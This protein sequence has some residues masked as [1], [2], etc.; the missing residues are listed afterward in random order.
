MPQETDPGSSEPL[1]TLGEIA[2]FI[3]ET[4][5]IPI[6]VSTVEKLA[7]PAIND[8]PKPA[9]YIG[10]RP[11]F[12]RDE[13]A[14]WAKARL[15]ASPKRSAHNWPDRPPKAKRTKSPDKTR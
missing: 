12:A 8:G 7:S 11:L 1:L 6:G 15:S 4:T 2:P 3:K 13:V 10:K 14:R 9:C 5:G